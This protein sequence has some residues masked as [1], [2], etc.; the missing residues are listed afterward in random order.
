MERKYP[1]KDKRYQGLKIFKDF[2]ATGTT[3]EEIIEEA[4]K[5]ARKHA[6]ATSPGPWGPLDSWNH[7]FWSFGNAWRDMRNKKLHTYADV[8]DTF[9]L[10][11]VL[12]DEQIDYVAQQLGIKEVYK[13]E[14][15]R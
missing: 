10:C 6:T 5:I 1:Y 13:A 4:L 9:P 15:Y 7:F 11:R 2:I 8:A 3:I 14:T 12:T